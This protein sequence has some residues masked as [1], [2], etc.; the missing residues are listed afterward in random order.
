[1][2]FSVSSSELSRGHLE[3]EWFDTGYVLLKANASSVERFSTADD[4][5]TS[6]LAECHKEFLEIM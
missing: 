1:V 2:N 5:D 6:D 3:E 4:D